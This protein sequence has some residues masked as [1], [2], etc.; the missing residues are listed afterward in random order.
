MPVKI[1][2]GPGPITNAHCLKEAVC[3]HT[4]KVYDACKEKDCLEDLRVILTRS[5]QEI[6]N[7]AINVKVRRAEVIWVFTDIEPVPFNRGYFTVDIKYFFNVTLEVFRGV[8]RPTEVNGLATFDKKV[9]LFGS[10]GNSKIFSSKYTP[11]G[12]IPSTWKKNNLPKAVVEVVDPIA[13]SARLV[14]CE[15]HCP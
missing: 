3:I 8:G 6:V 5:G 1:G 13:L 10:E 15:C 12:A 7:N 14:E 2:P 9:V 11:T 4:D